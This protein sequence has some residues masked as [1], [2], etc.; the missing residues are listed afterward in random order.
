MDS[1]KIAIIFLQGSFV[2]R[3]TPEIN[4][5]FWG[6]SQ[7]LRAKSTMSNTCGQNGLVRFVFYYYRGLQ[8]Y[9]RNLKLFSPYIIMLIPSTQHTKTKQNTDRLWGNLCLGVGTISMGKL[10]KRKMDG[11]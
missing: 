1:A 2:C 5:I 9:S 4:R 11:R 8:A 10:K 3:K 6:D 7:A